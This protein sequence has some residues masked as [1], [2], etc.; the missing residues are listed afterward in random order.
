MS[1]RNLCRSF[2]SGLT[3]AT[4][5]GAIAP[6]PVPL[7]IPGDNNVVNQIKILPPAH[8][9][10]YCFPTPEKVAMELP[11]LKTLILDKSD[12]QSLNLRI[13][14]P[15]S[16]KAPLIAG[17]RMLTIRRKK[18][19][20]H[21][22]LKRYHRDYFKYQTHHR[23]K[24]AKAEG[25]F[26]QRMHAIIDELETFDPLEHVKDTIARAERTWETSLAG[27]GRKKYPHWSQL[28]SLEELYG[29]PKITR[30]DKSYGRPAPEDEKKIDQLRKEYFRDYTRVT[31]KKAD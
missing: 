30:I 22:R 21:K 8:T 27:S 23:K 4:A 29:L 7:N 10:V 20:K 11:T 17:P 16:N 19:K 9:K 3:L 6:P 31:A 24:K 25:L 5:P 12:P 26:R 14:E 2:R 18:M 15:T 28:M 13:E 1:M